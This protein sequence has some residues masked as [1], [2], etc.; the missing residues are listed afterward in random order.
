MAA[1][2]RACALPEE[3]EDQ[4]DSQ[5]QTGCLCSSSRVI[6]VKGAGADTPEAGRSL[7]YG[8]TL[9]FQHGT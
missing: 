6:V 8:V 9:F 3:R 7:D 2:V 5:L 1:C 4:A